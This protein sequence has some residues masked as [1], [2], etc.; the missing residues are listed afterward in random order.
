M[1]ALVDT[2]FLL[3]LFNARDRYQKQAVQL[4]KSESKSLIIPAPVFPELFYMMSERTGYRDA[5]RALDE[6]AHSDYRIEPLL[7]ADMRRMSVIMKQ[8]EDARFD[9]V[10]VSIMALA[11]RLNITR[12]CTFDRR[13]FPIFRPAH[14]DALELLP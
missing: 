2:G 5:V 12:I 13:D 3:A 14:C 1:T 7:Q 11:E 10:D 8:Y 6:L 4:V 9:F